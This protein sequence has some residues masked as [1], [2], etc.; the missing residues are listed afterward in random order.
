M[1]RYNQWP[2]ELQWIT[3]LAIL[4]LFAWGLVRCAADGIEQNGI[5]IDLSSRL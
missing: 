3:A 1:R 5:A 4:G 2:P